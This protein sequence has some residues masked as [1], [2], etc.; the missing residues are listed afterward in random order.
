MMMC[1]NCLRGP[2]VDGY[3]TDVVVTAALISLGFIRLVKD[4]EHFAR[5]FAS[6]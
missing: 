5:E 2:G 4:A 3:E 1:W 6:H